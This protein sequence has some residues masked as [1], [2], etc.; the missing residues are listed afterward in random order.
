MAGEA[1]KGSSRI[2]GCKA[3][4]KEGLKGIAECLFCCFLQY[5]LRR[6]GRKKKKVKS[7]Y[8]FTMLTGERRKQ[9]EILESKSAEKKTQEVQEVIYKC[10]SFPVQNFEEE[11][12][13]K[14]LNLK[15]DCL[16]RA[17]E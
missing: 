4:I 15:T 17:V 7:K 12:G 2:I 14:V 6:V 10:L 1:V 16:V 11:D 13:K 5:R 3:G 8:D 9:K